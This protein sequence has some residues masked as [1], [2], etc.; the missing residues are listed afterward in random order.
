MELLHGTRNRT[1]IRS[2]QAAQTERFHDWSLDYRRWEKVF[3]A[4]PVIDVWMDELTECESAG[5]A[6]M[7]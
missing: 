5:V 7:T 2:P 4:G 1:P 6:V 3:V